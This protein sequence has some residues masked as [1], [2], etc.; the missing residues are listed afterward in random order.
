MINPWLKISHS[1]YEDHMKE[2]GQAQVLNELIKSYLNK[3]I[4]ENFALLGCSTGNGLEHVKSITR[5]V[6]AIDINPDYLAR[7]ERKFGRKINK[8]ITYNIDIQKSDLIFNSIDLF[9]AGLVLEYVEPINALSKIIKT[10]NKNGV[11]VVVIQKSKPTFFETKTR[12]KSLEQLSN[13]SKE[14]DE[15]EINTF[16][17]SKNLELIERKEIE[18]TENK[19]F[20]TF[21]YKLKEK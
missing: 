19:S 13:I 15:I 10:L 1:D 21:E 14:V 6:Y 8:L 7:T 17:Q 2:V 4:P 9:F 16:I 11:K 5:K 3:Y 12:Y 20:V 18:L